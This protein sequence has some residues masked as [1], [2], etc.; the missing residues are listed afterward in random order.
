[1]PKPP[2][3]SLGLNRAGMPTLRVRKNT[4]TEDAIWDA[5][6]HAQ[7]AHPPWTPKEFLA[8]VL[9]AWNGGLEMDKKEAKDVFGGR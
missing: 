9:S 4:S 3:V 2:G 5:V 6:F 7:T 8:E 1:M